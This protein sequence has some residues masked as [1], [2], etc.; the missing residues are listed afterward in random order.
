MGIKPR[1]K[2]DALFQAEYKPHLKLP[3]APR[4]HA[5][6]PLGLTTALCVHRVGQEKA[7]QL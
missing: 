5:P 1:H 4:S 7:P 6:L 2:K 3:P